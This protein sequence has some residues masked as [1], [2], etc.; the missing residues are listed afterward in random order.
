ME[1]KHAFHVFV[2]NFSTTWKLLVY[3]LIVL[4]VTIG[5]C[6]AVVLPALNSLSHTVQYGELRDSFSVLWADMASLNVEKLYVHLQDV[7]AAFGAF[8]NLLSDKTGL[9][10][11]VAVCLCIVFLLNRFLTGVGNFVTGSLVHDKMVMRTN[12]SFTFTLFKNIKRAT[13]YAL[14]YAPLAFVYDSACAVIMWAIIRIGL[15]TFSFTLIKIFIVAIL[16]LVFSAVKYTFITDWLPSLIHGKM[17]QRKAFTYTFNRKGKR[18]G[19]VFSNAV[20]LKL[21]IFALNVAAGLFTFG[22]GLLVTIPASSLILS[23]YCFVNYYDRNRLKYF[24]D[25]YTVIGPKKDKPV[26][27]EEFFKGDE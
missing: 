17:K 12:S 16:F 26:S 27:R 18:T 14:I 23:A 13:L 10:A 20:V 25:D 5:L 19:A 4:A 6:C 8:K 15:K 11:A 7:R 24:V 22:A 2:D 1:F 9:V 3:R 21:T